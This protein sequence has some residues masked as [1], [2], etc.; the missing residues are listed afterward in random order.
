MENGRKEAMNNIE[1]AIEDQKK[2]VWQMEGQKILMNAKRVCVILN[3]ILS[4]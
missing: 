4:I 3:F 1:K 2:S